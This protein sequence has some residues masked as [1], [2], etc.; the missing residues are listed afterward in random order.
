MAFS[1]LAH[2]WAVLHGIRVEFAEAIGL[3]C[4]RGGAA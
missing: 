4:D 3:G 2:E 1:I